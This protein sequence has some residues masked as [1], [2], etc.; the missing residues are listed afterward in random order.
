VF[1]RP[2]EAELKAGRVEVHPTCLGIS[3]TTPQ[4]GAVLFA[5]QIIN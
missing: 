3:E 4:P 1:L 5:D 2:E